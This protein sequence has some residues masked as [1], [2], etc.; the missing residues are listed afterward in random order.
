MNIVKLLNLLQGYDDGN[1]DFKEVA[2]EM[3]KVLRTYTKGLIAAGE[4]AE[5]LTI[6]PIERAVGPTDQ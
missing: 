3:L 1:V 5:E 6:L 2:L 4:S